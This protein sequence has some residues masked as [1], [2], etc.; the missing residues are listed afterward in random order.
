MASPRSVL[1]H[2]SP[3][4]FARAF[5]AEVGLPPGRYVDRVRLETARRLL[6]DG[7]DGVEQVARACGY[8]T[9]EAM[10]RAFVRALGIPPAEY[11]R[12]FRPALATAAGTPGPAA[13]TAD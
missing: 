7:G 5:H 13:S 10:R 11:R 6:E 8:G 2:L 9:P 1:T 4:Q 3:R 12:R